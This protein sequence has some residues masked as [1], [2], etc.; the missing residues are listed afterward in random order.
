MNESGTLL[1]SVQS[2]QNALNRSGA[3]SVYRTVCATFFFV[4]QI[5]LQGAGVVPLIG[6]LVTTGMAKHMRV[7]RKRGLRGRSSTADELADIEGIA[8]L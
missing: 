1:T 3:R 8:T 4:L 6:E 2:F 5:M 7:D